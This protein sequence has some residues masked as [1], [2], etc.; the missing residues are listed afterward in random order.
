MPRFIATAGTS[1]AQARFA[2][3]DGPVCSPLASL[4]RF[5]FFLTNKFFHLLFFFGLVGFKG[6]LS[7]LDVFLV[8]PGGSSKWKILSKFGPMGRFAEP[9]K[10]LKPGRLVRHLAA[11][12]LVVNGV[13]LQ[14][15]CTPF[16]RLTTEIISDQRP[17]ISTRVTGVLVAIPG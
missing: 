2:C 7:L 8:F 6:N 10:M 14:T 11:Q 5:F 16:R 9:G 13:K 3:W 17:S 12:R 1:T 15:H 4:F